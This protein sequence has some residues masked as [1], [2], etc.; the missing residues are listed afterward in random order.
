MNDKAQIIAALREEFN[1]WQKLLTDVG[2]EQITAL[3]FLQSW[4]TKGKK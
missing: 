1:R 3:W 2:E 4:L